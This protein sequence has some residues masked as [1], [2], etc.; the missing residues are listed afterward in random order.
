MSMR[1]HRSNYLTVPR[2]VVTRLAS[3]SALLR[4]H[5]PEPASVDV[6][7]ALGHLQGVEGEVRRACVARHREHGPSIAAHDSELD[8]CV[9][10]LVHIARDR[11]GHWA[12][13][14][15]DGIQRLAATAKPGSFDFA[16]RITKAERAK[17][18]T[19]LLLARGLDFTRSPYAEQAEQMRVLATI[20]A[21][22]G[23]AAE[24][25]ALI[26]ADFMGAL[27]QARIAYDAMVEARALRTAGSA[28]N[29]NELRFEL[30]RAIEGY[31]I[32]VLAMLREDDPDN[33]ARIRAAL[34]PFDALTEQ[35][36]R[37]RA[38][39]SGGK[40]SAPLAPEQSVDELLAE[41]QAFEAELGLAP[42]TV[43]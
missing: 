15:R 5:A 19:E 29:L 21:E 9:D 35:L 30:A 40:Q 8:T 38:R 7:A 16:E 39:A 43:G 34:L 3:L 13:F 27:G 23:V 37:E 42:E 28:V 26:G 11:L 14:E 1:I 6:E 10:V 31:L 22:E 17:A 18:L 20:I 12:V 32:A 24:L 2:T 41:Q 4:K 33:V 25:D 36:A